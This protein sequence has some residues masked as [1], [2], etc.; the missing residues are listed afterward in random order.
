MKEVCLLSQVWNM[1]KQTSQNT[2]FGHTDGVNHC[3]F[4]PDDAY[5][6]TSSNDGTLKV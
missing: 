2:M 3:C 5:L 4:S 1:N 6:A